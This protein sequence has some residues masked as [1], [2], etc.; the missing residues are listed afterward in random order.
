MHRGVAAS[1]GP[2]LTLAI[3]DLDG[4]SSLDSDW[5]RRL[6]ES[7]MARKVAEVEVPIYGI[8]ETLEEFGRTN[9]DFASIDIEGLDGPVIE[10]WDFRR[11]RPFL[12]CV[13]TGVILKGRHLKDRALYTVLA[14]RGYQPLFETF[15]N[16]I[17]VDQNAEHQY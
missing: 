11:F 5:T 10:A 6:G 1:S 8:N 4:L 12:L 17:F 9:I 7:G 2:P 15:S 3:M 14:D 16:T 13:E